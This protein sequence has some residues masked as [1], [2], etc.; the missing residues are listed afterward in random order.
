MVSMRLRGPAM[1]LTIFVDETDRW[2]HHPVHA[3]ITRR[4]HEAGLAGASVLH[5]IEGYGAS[6]LIHKNHLLTLGDKLPVAVVI[7]DTEPA[8]RAFLPQLDEVVEEGLVILD[9]TEAYRYVDVD[10]DR[11]VPRRRHPGRPRWPRRASRRERP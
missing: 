10:P 4:A 5:G 2:N 1:R 3:E 11:L 9:E 7:V 8:I 6:T